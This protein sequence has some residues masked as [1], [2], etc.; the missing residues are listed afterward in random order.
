[1]RQMQAISRDHS[2]T[3]VHLDV[4][5]I[6]PVHDSQVR[7]AGA[8]SVPR[9]PTVPSPLDLLL[10]GSASAAID[11]PAT[12]SPDRLVTGPAN[13]SADRGK[14]A[15]SMCPMQALEPCPAFS[16]QPDSLLCSYCGCDRDSHEEAQST[17]SVVQQTA[18]RKAHAH[19]TSPDFPEDF[20][21]PIL[22]RTL[23]ACSS[24]VTQALSQD[25]LAAHLSSYVHNALL[26]C[27]RN[28]SPHSDVKGLAETLG[29][30]F[31][32]VQDAAVLKDALLHQLSSRL[33]QGELDEL[34]THDPTNQIELD[35]SRE[36]VPIL[37][38][39]F[40]RTCQHMCR[41]IDWSNMVLSKLT[42]TVACNMRCAIVSLDKW[43]RSAVRIGKC[44]LPTSLARG[45]ET[46]QA[47]ISSGYVL[48]S[49][50]RTGGTGERVD[51][52]VRID[53]LKPG[54]YA[55]KKRNEGIAFTL[56]VPAT[57][58]IQEIVGFL[59]QTMDM[60]RSDDIRLTPVPQNQLTSCLKQV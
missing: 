44:K 51:V 41:D 40:L 4:G 33:L 28:R 54:R 24:A 20:A 23:E 53:V 38:A 14:C 6:G 15:S 22:A 19:I 60:S 1:M 31:F 47:A 32:F 8:E 9:V 25:T 13:V 50:E 59:E 35:F 29:R 45:C 5:W 11:E 48:R 55:A 3:F 21:Q 46:I 10:Q 58:C 36:L 39:D 49:W 16:R 52:A 43:P 2:G 18:T 56:D 26:T 37:G 57:A 27:K 17:V 30:L 12:T 42:K 7:L 34:S